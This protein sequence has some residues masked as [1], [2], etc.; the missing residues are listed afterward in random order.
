M[1]LYKI[2]KDDNKFGSTNDNFNFQVTIF[3][4][5]YGQFD[6]LVDGY[7]QDIFI[8]LLGLT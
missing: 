7:I 4:D 1:I 3:L 5:K 2:Y 8:R 6:L